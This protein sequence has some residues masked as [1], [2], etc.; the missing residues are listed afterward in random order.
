MM[1]FPQF[2]QRT[3]TRTLFSGEAFVSFVA[4]SGYEAIVRDDVVLLQ[5][6]NGILELRSK[7]QQVGFRV[8]VTADT[9][10]AWKGI[11]VEQRPG[12]TRFVSR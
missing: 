6:E 1:L 2:K 8:L 7:R 4:L 10:K 3:H 9:G 5:L 11:V 12:I